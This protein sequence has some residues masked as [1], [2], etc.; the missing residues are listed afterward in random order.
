MPSSTDEVHFRFVDR[1]RRLRDQANW[2]R[3]HPDS[4]DRWTDAEIKASPR[5]Q[6]LGTRPGTRKYPYVRPADMPRSYSV[7]ADG[8]VREAIYAPHVSHA[9]VEPEWRQALRQTLPPEMLDRHDYYASFNMRGWFVPYPNGDK[10]SALDDSWALVYW[11]PD[12]KDWADAWDR[13]V[14]PWPQDDAVLVGVPTMADHEAMIDQSDD[15]K[16]TVRLACHRVV[17]WSHDLRPA[18]NAPTAKRL[19]RR[20]SASQAPA[21]NPRSYLMDTFNENDPN[22]GI[23]LRVHVGKGGR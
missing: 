19:P 20:P 9:S 5:L 17:D 11:S 16:T 12:P 8:S 23:P 1:I 4:I 10:P 6:E 2:P 15:A 14:E 22:Q 7:Q 13:P 3:E 21:V 18:N